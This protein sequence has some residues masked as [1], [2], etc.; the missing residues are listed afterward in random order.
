MNFQS[1]AAAALR[2]RHAI[3]QRAIGT[4]DALYW[5]MAPALAGTDPEELRL[6]A[7]RCLSHAPAVPAIWQD[8]GSYNP[9]DVWQA[10][11]WRAVVLDWQTLANLALSRAAEIEALRTT[12]PQP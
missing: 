8:E 5:N 6:W 4:I 10:A 1:A 12:D 3:C 2:G 11:F 7:E 9:P